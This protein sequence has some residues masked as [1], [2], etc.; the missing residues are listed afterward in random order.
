MVT[1]RKGVAAVTAIV[2]AV[3]GVAI[4]AIG[5][6]AA[7]SSASLPVVYGFDGSSGWSHG[8]VKPGAIYFGAGG[9][10]LVRDLTWVSWKQAAA[11]ARGVRWSDNCVPTC[12]AGRYAKIP[13]EMSLYRVRQR[14]GVSYFSRM[15]LRWTIG[16]KQYKSSYGWS[17]GPVPSAPPFWS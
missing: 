6:T 2:A 11:V 7:S 13:V 3:I 14:N 15:T 9:S 8:L 10:L 1:S 12:A 5:V 16:G 17:R 4:A